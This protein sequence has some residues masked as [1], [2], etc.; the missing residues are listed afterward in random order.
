VS[1]VIASAMDR[2]NASPST[3]RG[4]VSGPLVAA[5]TAVSASA[6]MHGPASPRP[7]RLELRRVREGVA[8]GR[9]ARRRPLFDVIVL[10]VLLGLYGSRA[11]NEHCRK[12]GLVLRH[13]LDRVM[14]ANKQPLSV[15]AFSKSLLPSLTM[16]FRSNGDAAARRCW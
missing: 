8:I 7:K 6:P 12:I 4:C 3:H 10:A 9:L 16:C 1:T 2:E 11:L 5:R 14:F 13:L 15:I